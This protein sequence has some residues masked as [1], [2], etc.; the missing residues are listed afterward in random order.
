MTTTQAPTRHDRAHD[1]AEITAH[2]RGLFEAYQRGDRAAIERGHTHDWRGFQLASRKI[3]H[4]ID[5]YM[6]VA[7]R[8]LATFHIKRFSL[9][10]VE[11][12]FHGDFAVVFYV[13]REWLESGGGTERCVLFRSIDHYRRENGRWNQCGSHITGLAEPENAPRVPTDAERAELLAVRESVW[14][15]FFA[16]DRARLEALV[17]EELIAVNVGSEPWQNRD[18]AFAA[19][20]EFARSGVRLVELAFDRTDIL[21]YGDVALLFTRYRYVADTNGERSTTAGRGTEVFVR[22]G[23]RWWNSGWH[24]DS[25]A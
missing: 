18:E 2:I 11:F 3:V 22:R 19:A 15:A 10:Q 25:G 12:E 13:A 17:P 20:E 14:R 1:E 9:D 23:G 24:L 7:D 21:M 8:L 16:N 6:G 5:E 4:G